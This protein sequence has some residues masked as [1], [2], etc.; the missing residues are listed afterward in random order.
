MKKTILFILLFSGYCL[1]SKAQNQLYDSPD[2]AQ[3]VTSDIDNFWK[4]FQ[5]F[6]R[7]TTVNPF[8]PEY[9]AIGSPGIAGFTPGRIQNADHLFA[10]VKKRRA[11][12]EKVMSN[13]L[14]I[15]EKE[16]QFRST[17][18][19]LK[20]LYPQAKFPT[21]YFVIGAH[22]SGGTSGTNG[23]FIGAE[24][25]TN[26]DNMPFIV[27]H[28]LIHFQQTFPSENPT[29]LQQSIVEGSADFIGELIS[30]SQINIAAHTY[31]NVHTDA[32]CKEFVSKMNDRS[33]MDWMYG[34]SKKDDRPND[35]GYWM[36]Y[37]ITAQ[38]YAK[39]TD[40][41]QAIY[42]ILNIKDYTAFLNK[43]GYLDKYLGK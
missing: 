22:N 2:S 32:L 5:H 42:D 17:F 14:R 26:I 4:A 1:V 27:A 31:A 3:F 43:S 33:Y 20:Y 16:K 12:Y 39:A 6:K 30:G 28:E 29:L 40:K 25:Q 10:V 36:G 15:K 18:Y 9:I 8:G 24:M 23:L 19:A 38:Y 7:D 13:T 34:T 37:Q 11:D 35:L 41:K 21:V